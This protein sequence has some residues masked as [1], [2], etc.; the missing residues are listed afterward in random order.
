MGFATDVFVIGGGPAG[1]AAAI[2]ARAKGLR[3]TVADGGV[4]PIDKPC[5]EGLL[6]DTLAALRELGVEVHPADGHALRGIRFVGSGSVLAA[7]FPAGCGIGIRRPVLHQRLIDRAAEVGVALLWKTPV[8]GMSAE[9]VLA[10]GELVSARWIVGADGI[11]SR[12]RKWS[13]LEAKRLSSRRFAQRQ[14]YRIAPWTDFVEIYWGE[15]AQAYVT[16]VG[17]DE[18]GVVTVSQRSSLR[19]DSLAMEF[20]ELA[21]RLAGALP[22]TAERGAVTSMQRLGALH[23]GNV[24]LVGDASGSVDAITGEGLCLGFRQALALAD[25]LAAGKLHGYARAHRRLARRAAVM[26]RLMLTLDGRTKLRERVFRALAS[27][28]DLFGRLV[29]IH[30]GAGSQAQLASVGAVLGWRFV[31][32]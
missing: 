24:A 23:R 11:N 20:P 21:R 26:G 22:V 5:G 29:A 16:P 14:H 19:G 9:G 3:V 7:G 10:G 15:N 17:G 31:G 1:L 18:I 8:S 13:G 32:A 28:T 30:V 2:A 6:P 4:P 27:D 12:V 25:V